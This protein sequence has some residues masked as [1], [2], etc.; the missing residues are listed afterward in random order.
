VEIFPGNRL[1]GNR[2]LKRGVWNSGESQRRID[3]QRRALDLC[4]LK[5]A[6]S[7]HSLP[8]NILEAKVARCSALRIP[9]GINLLDRQAD[10]A[11]EYQ[12]ASYPAEM[13]LQ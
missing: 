9:T 13:F 2:P 3:R 11:R 5:R 10:V 6:A 12:P 7:W 4:F 1:S 8:K